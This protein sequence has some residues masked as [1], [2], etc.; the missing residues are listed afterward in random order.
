MLLVTFRNYGIRIAPPLE[1][2]VS[3]IVQKRQITP[4]F[5]T[6]GNNKKVEQKLHLIFLTF[7]LCL[8][9]VAVDMIQVYERKSVDTPYCIAY[10][11]PV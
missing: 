7:I 11:F 4:V 10:P 3:K 6:I 1:A 8:T 5:Q 2:L 9:G